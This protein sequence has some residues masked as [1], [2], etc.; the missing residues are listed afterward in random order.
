MS[1]ELREKRKN[2]A[3]Q[4]NAI[5]V[6]AKDAKRDLTAEE[7]TQFD[8]LHDEI[9]KLRAQIDRIERQE[10]LEKELRE[11]Q[12]RLAG[13]Q[14]GTPGGSGST[15][16]EQEAE[17]RKAAWGEWLRYGMAGLTP[18]HRQIMAEGR[19]DLPKEARALAAGVDTAGGYTVHD[20]FVPR[21]ETALKAFSGIRNTRATIMRTNSGNDMIMPT[22]DD[23]SNKGARLAENTQVTEQDITFGS[24]TLRAYMYTSKLVRVSIQFLQD[25]DVAGIEGWLADRLGE[26]IGRITAEE[27]ITGTG[28]NMPEGLS[29]ASTEGHQ[30]ASQTAI[31]YNDLVELE[32]SVDAAYRRQAEFLLGDKALRNLKK[33]KDGEGRPLWV[34]GVATREP[35]RILGYPYAVDME[36]PDPAASVKSLYFGDFSKFHIRD[37]RSMQ[38]LRL[39]ERYADYLQVGFLL[40]SRHDSM[41]LDAGTHPIKHFA[42]SA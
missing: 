27:F 23:T 40:F 41:L 11:S 10:D 33:L 12:G 4:A 32:H 19:G 22:S 15:T 25:S 34:P 39:T 29:E 38:M 42:Q 6:K 18:E 16:P 2:L 31:T 7:T 8:K 28:A 36:I 26:R 13:G 17:E 30:G 24:K 14:Q 5:L 37:V 35:D 21:I 1:K 9:D 3:E 20:D